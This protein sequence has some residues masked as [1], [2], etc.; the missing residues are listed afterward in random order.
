M[1]VDTK[2]EIEGLRELNR[3]FRRLGSD[4][5]VDLKGVHLESA[6]VVEK[7]A[8][9]VVPVRSGRLKDTLR[10]SGT[11]RGAQVRAGFARVPYAGPIHFGWRKRNIR[12]QP[13]LYDALDDRRAEVL[14]T[15]EDNLNKLIR[16]HDL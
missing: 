4:A 14:R 15:Y 11:M 3:A 2:I 7:R 12:P 16:K 6:R 8:R 1:A 5:T 10:S 9:Q 13:F